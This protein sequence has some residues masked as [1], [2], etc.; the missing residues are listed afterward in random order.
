[1]SEID[2]FTDAELLKE[3]EIRKDKVKELERRKREKTVKEFIKH[4]ESL[5]SLMTHDRSSCN[6]AYGNNDGYHP[7]HGVAYCSKCAL[8]GLHEHHDDVEILFDI[9]LTQIRNEE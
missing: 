3:L 9:R 8:E 5:L 4:R 7:E 1:M 6:N 2:N